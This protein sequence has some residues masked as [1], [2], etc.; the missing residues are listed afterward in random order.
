MPG[1]LANFKPVWSNFS[2]PS[3]S[4]ADLPSPPAPEGTERAARASC[5]LKSQTRWLPV[6]CPSER[7]RGC[8]GHPLAAGGRHSASGRTR[9]RPSAGMLRSAPQ[10]C[11]V[12]TNHSGCLSDSQQLLALIPSHRGAL[13][14]QYSDPSEGGE[15]AHPHKTQPAFGCGSVQL[16][17]QRAGCAVRYAP[18]A[19]EIVQPSALPNRRRPSYVEGTEYSTTHRPRRS[20][21]QR[22][23]LPPPSGQGCW[24]I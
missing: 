1:R 8:R 2:S 21:L 12:R 11:V 3:A 10:S 13:T 6:A 9:R 14:E 16:H 15:G 5:C 22:P 24:S 4:A 17:L 18:C 23:P 20:N 19:S 7:R